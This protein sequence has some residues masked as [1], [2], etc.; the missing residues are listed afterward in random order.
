VHLQTHALASWL[1]AEAPPTSMSRRDRILVLAAGLA[2]DLDALSLLGGIAAYQK[3]HH[4]LFHNVVGAAV[5]TMA[6]AALARSRFTVLVLSTVAFHLHLFL[7]LL[8]S[9]G[10]D[11]SIWSIPYL[12]PFSSRAFSWS[13]QWPL[14]SLQN[15]TLTGLLV[16]MNWAVAVRRDRTIVQAFSP[17]TDARVVEILKRWWPF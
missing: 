15:V 2:P 9:G 7:D 4:L 14:G 11:G 10:P 17:R 6:C 8:G 5:T 3:W 12:A 13:G 1:L 16:L